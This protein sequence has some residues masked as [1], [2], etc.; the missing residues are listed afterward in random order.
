VR[1]AIIAPPWVAVPPPAYGGTEAVLDTLARGLATAGHDVL[2]FTTGDST[3]PVPRAFDFEYSLGVGVGGA[4]AELR[5][6]IAAYDAVAGYD[7]VHDHT[8]VG[9]V[10]A[11]VRPELA[12]VTTNHGPFE[13]DLGRLYRTVSERV[14]VIAI[15]HDQASSAEGV[16]LAGVI[17]HGLDLG[18]FPFGEGEGGYA[19]FLG[20]M[21]PD[22]G[23]HTAAR[24]ARAAGMPLRIAAKMA[25]IAEQEYFSALVEPLLGGDIEYVGEVGGDEKLELLAG[26]A[27]LLNPVA[28]REPFGMVMAEAAACGTPVVATPCGAAPEVVIAGV[29]GFLGQDEAALVSALGRLDEIDRKVCRRVA[30]TRFSSER[31]VAEHVEVYEAVAEGCRPA[32]SPTGQPDR[33]RPRS[34]PNEPRTGPVP[35]A[36]EQAAG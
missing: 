26:A 2:L 27:C 4:A 36:A 32:S 7:V 25:E 15:S 29:T 10:Y 24:V 33:A 17:H 22:K 3:C 9:P 16:R 28:W 23:V 19:L 14:P 8:L 13:S 30:E 35:S 31:M 5:H 12:V 18:A 1:V 21:S 34:A 6:T 11:H 20:R